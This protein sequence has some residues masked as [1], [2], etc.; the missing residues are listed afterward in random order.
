MQVR[1]LVHQVVRVVREPERLAGL[2]YSG[3]L[4]A[5]H[6]LGEPSDHGVMQ[7][8][9]G[10]SAEAFTRL[11][12][13]LV[14]D[15]EFFDAIDRRHQAVRGVPLRLLGARSGED[16]DRYYRL[17]YYATRVT[18]PEVVVETG[19]FDGF[20]TAILLKALHE[21]GTGQL[22]SIDMPAT[23]PIADSTT[24]MR[25]TSLP[26]GCTPGWIVPDELRDRWTLR[27]GDSGTLLGPWLAELGAVDV[28]FHDSMHT[29]AHMTQEFRAVWPRLTAGG[30]LLSD[31][32]F[33]N[34]ALARFA[35]SVGA[36]VRIARGVGLV[37]KP[38]AMA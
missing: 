13:D 29:A 7:E 8:W 19:V 37:V 14:G 36:R 10:A 17:L 12:R 1:Q 27:L 30:V 23:T 18:R 5:L 2:H 22:C 28:F 38:R 21:N 20:S 34:R 32:V 31:D 33:F 11:E 6:T 24:G 16:Y 25:F 4:A 35:R 15:A 3:V 26:P 9:F